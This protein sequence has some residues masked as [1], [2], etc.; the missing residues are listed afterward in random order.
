MVGEDST[1]T[2]IESSGLIRD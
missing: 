2:V 1:F